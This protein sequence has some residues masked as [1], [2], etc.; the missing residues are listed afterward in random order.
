MSDFKDKQDAKL[1]YMADVMSMVEKEPFTV[2]KIDIYSP[3]L[4]LAGQKWYTGSLVVVGNEEYLKRFNGNKINFFDKSAMGK[5]NTELEYS[6]YPEDFAYDGGRKKAV[7]FQYD[8]KRDGYDFK[9]VVNQSA[10][11]NNYYYLNDAMDLLGALENPET[12]LKVMKTDP[13]FIKDNMDYPADGYADNMV[14][15]LNSGRKK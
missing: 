6:G 14:E 1:N 9:G 5:I 4:A 8:D 2:R 11:E 10:Y 15:S 12:A 3:F 13:S 7:I